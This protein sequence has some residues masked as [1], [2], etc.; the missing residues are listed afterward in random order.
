MELPGKSLI[1]GR[2][3]GARSELFRAKNPAT[4]E[5]LEPVFH[6]A[7]LADAARA[8]DEAAEAFADLRRRS[9]VE[10]ARFVETIADEIEALGEA[11]IERTTAE[12]ALPAARII[13]ERGRTCAQLRLF[14][15][16]VREGS[17]V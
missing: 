4:G 5:T 1:A 14:A 9:P 8:V 3:T 11:L 15:A 16:T 17:W 10:R 13:G 12:T 7:S 6:A 2:P